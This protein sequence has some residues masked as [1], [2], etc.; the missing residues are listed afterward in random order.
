MGRFRFW[1]CSN[2]R[3]IDLDLAGPAHPFTRVCDQTG[4]FQ[5][6][7]VGNDGLAVLAGNLAQVFDGR[8]NAT[9]PVIRALA[10]GDK[11]ELG[12]R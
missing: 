5:L 9:R 6:S 3:L 4:G 8:G 7:H 12:T 2:S 10:Q 1:D 11:R